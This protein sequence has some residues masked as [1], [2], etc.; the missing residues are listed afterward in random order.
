MVCKDTVSMAGVPLLLA[1]RRTGCSPQGVG[2]FVDRLWR[3]CLIP[4]KL[5]S[6]WGYLLVTGVFKVKRGYDQLSDA[7]KHPT[8]TK[9]PLGHVR[10]SV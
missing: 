7:S 10:E 8:V 3:I 2:N 9:T 5:W 1:T 4:V 6:M